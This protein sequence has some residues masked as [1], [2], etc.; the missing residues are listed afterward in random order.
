MADAAYW[1]IHLMV[2]L[3][4]FV[5]SA[6]SARA[7]VT[8]FFVLLVELVGLVGMVLPGG[9]D[10]TFTLELFGGLGLFIGLPLSLGRGKLTWWFLPA[11]AAGVFAVLRV[12]LFFGEDWLTIRRS[13]L[14][15][16]VA[17][18]ALAGGMLAGR[19]LAVLAAS[20]WNQMRP[21]SNRGSGA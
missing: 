17:T 18:L 7:T 4:G 3:L 13:G 8:V 1:V 14:Q 15:T 12:T 16:L 11:L 9:A 21:K 10:A 6:I 20:G 2:G 5:L 19:C